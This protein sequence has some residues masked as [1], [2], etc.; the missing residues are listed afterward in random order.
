MNLSKLNLFLFLLR[1]VCLFVSFDILLSVYYFFI[2][3]AFYDFL[4]PI[5]TCPPLLNVEGLSQASKPQSAIRHQRELSASEKKALQPSHPPIHRRIHATALSDCLQLSTKEL[6]FQMY[7]TQF[8]AMKQGAYLDCQEVMLINNSKKKIHW[9][10]DLRNNVTLD[11]DIFR[12][13]HSSL[14]P[15]IGTSSSIGPEGEIESKEIFAFKI[16]FVPTKPGTYKTRIPLYVNNNQ[17]TPYTYID[18][19]A[20]LIMPSLIFEPRRL[21]L[22]PVPLD[23]ESVKTVRIR[24]KGFEKYV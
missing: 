22:P 23:I 1:F 5:R 9:Q 13:L 16:N 20:E 8:N 17:Q 7:S 14:V 2:Q 24:S 6:H 10:L 3:I 4:L 12:I 11:N 15:F 18:I 21:I 19:T